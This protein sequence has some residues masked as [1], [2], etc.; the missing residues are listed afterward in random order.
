MHSGTLLSGAFSTPEKGAM[1]LQH[2]EVARV[3]MSAA[4]RAVAVGAV[5]AYARECSSTQVATS[6][7]LPDTKPVSNML[8][9][10]NTQHLVTTLSQGNTSC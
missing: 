5:E 8:S 4:V 10:N 2:M 6:R 9:A 1:R 7:H 3:L